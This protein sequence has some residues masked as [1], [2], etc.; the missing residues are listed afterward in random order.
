MRCL[1]LLFTLSILSGCSS[2]LQER[3]TEDGLHG[4]GM[5]RHEETGPMMEAFRLNQSF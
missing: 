2:Y 4:P 5:V 3:Q 1:L